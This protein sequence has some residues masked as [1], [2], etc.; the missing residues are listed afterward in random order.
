MKKLSALLFSTVLILLLTACNGG[1]TKTDDITSTST[2]GITTTTMVDPDTTPETATAPPEMDLSALEL[3][4]YRIDDEGK[5]W[6]DIDSWRKSDD[7]DLFRK[8][9][10]GAWENSNGFFGKDFPLYLI[11]DSEK[12]SIMDNSV[13]RF[14]DFY[15]ISENV[16][17]FNLHGS[18][19]TKVCWLDTNNPDIMYIESE[20]GGWF[21]FIGKDENYK[22]HFLTKTDAPPNELEDGFL[23]IFRLREISRDYGIA[24]DMLLD[25]KYID[26]SETGTVLSLRHN[27]WLY[28]NPVYLVSEAPD[29]LEFRTQ[30]SNSYYDYDLSKWVYLTM[31]VNYTIEKI[32]GEWVRTLEF[33]G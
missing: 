30:V 18:G 3:I 8:Y 31:D 13:W 25:I 23:S 15:M 26:Y 22:T 17:A 11:D 19:D 16:L 9:F 5:I 2:D 12:A 33:D 27:D 28:F 20:N 24:L 29:K 21:Y 6:V 4:G 10:F 7:Y 32:G 1:D 14:G